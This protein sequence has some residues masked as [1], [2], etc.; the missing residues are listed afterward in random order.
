MRMRWG[1]PAL[2]LLQS[3]SWG[4]LLRVSLAQPSFPHPTRCCWVGALPGADQL[5]DGALVYMF[6][7][8]GTEGRM[9]GCAQASP[10]HLWGKW[11][12]AGTVSGVNPQRGGYLPFLHWSHMFESCEKVD[13]KSSHHIQSELWLCMLDRLWWLFDYIYSYQVI[14]HQKLI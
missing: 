13:L 7:Q 14:I 9:G 10:P 11:D 12:R 6:T 1:A 2:S 4:F 8:A 3:R 5:S